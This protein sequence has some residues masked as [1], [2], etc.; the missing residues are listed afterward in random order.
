MATLIPQEDYWPSHWESEQ[1]SVPHFSPT[2]GWKSS[3]W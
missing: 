2:E 1:D 3:R